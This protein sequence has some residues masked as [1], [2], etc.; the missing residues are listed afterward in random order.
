VGEAGS[1][2]LALLGRRRREAQH[3]PEL[4]GSCGN[5]E[6]AQQAFGEGAVSIFAAGGS[7][8]LKLGERDEVKG[9]LLLGRQRVWLFGRLGV[10]LK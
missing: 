8:W 9:G 10:A 5:G 7:V 6:R 2:Q 1:R 4:H 3:L